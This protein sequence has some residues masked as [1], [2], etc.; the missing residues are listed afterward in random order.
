VDELIGGLSGNGYYTLGYADDI[1]ILIHR[2]FPNT[3]SELLQKALSMV[4][5]WCDR[6]QLSIN[7]QKMVIVP[8]T[9]KRDVRGLREPTFSGQ[10]LQLTTEV[11]YLGL[12]LD[13][14]LTWKAQLKNVMNKAY[15]A[16]WTCKGK[17]GKTWGLKPRVVHWIFTMVIRSV[18]TY[19]ST[20]WSDTM[21]AGQ[22]S[23]RY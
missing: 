16:F 20:V 5:Q 19:G 13:N 8:I 11:R 4:Q 14:G 9:Q 17:F 15:K 1:T 12:I 6:T 7:P 10:T 23:V 22:S 21:S 3:V 2:K 18:L